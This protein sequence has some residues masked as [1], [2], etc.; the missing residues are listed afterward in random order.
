[1]HK[2]NSFELHRQKSKWWCPIFSESGC[3]W[4]RYRD[5]WISTDYRYVGC[6]YR[7]LIALHNGFYN[8]TTIEPNVMSYLV[9]CGPLNSSAFCGSLPG[10]CIVIWLIPVLTLHWTFWFHFPVNCSRKW[11]KAGNLLYNPFIYWLRCMVAEWLPQPMHAC[12][13]ISIHRPA[14]YISASDSIMY[15]NIYIYIL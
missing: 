6:K 8:Y 15:I 4:A 13:Y 9:W 14:T 12:R 10:I 1:M 5:Y 7:Y 11:S 3:N 2:Y